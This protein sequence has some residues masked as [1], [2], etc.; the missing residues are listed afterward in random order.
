MVALFALLRTLRRPAPLA[1]TLALAAAM[2]VA[3]D[4][5]S[6]T[7]AGFWLSFVATAAL[8]AAGSAGSG[9]RGAVG[10]FARA[11]MAITVV[12][13]PVLAATFGRLSLVAPL[14]NAVAIP[15]FS[16]LILPAVLLGT[17][18]AVLAPA[19]SALLWRCSAGSWTVP[20]PSWNGSPPGPPRAWR[21]RCNLAA[22]M[23]GAG[24]LAFG[25]MLVPQQGLCAA[26]AVLLIAL[27]CGRAEPIEP[28]AFTLT[29]IDVGQGLA[30]VVET[31]GHVLRVRHR[32]AV[33]RRDGRRPR[34]TAAVPALARHPQDRPARAEPRRPGSRRRRAADRGAIAVRSHAGAARK[35]C[36]RPTKPARRGAAMDVGRRDVSASLHPPG[37]IRGQRQRPLLRVARQP[38]PAAPRSCWR[39]RKRM[40]SRMLTARRSLPTSSSSRTTAAQPPRRR[41]WSRRC[42]RAS[43]SRPPASAIAGG[44]R[45]RTWWRAGARPERR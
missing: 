12:L 18:I 8:F 3:A 9:W 32:P 28:G 13:A 36:R 42:R 11:Q 44:C 5:L 1:G 10:G 24:V 26:A 2:L 23:A 33:A 30:A 20:G 27:V 40:R 39:I 29:V 6:I 7:S 43:P 34:F 21:P 22:L 16:L 38:A 35:P 41:R 15:V 45:A 31:S 4:P 25:A 19:A 14:V 17:A 37:G